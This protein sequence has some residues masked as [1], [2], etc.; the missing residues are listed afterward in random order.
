MVR[1]EKVKLFR[2]LKPFPL[3]SL[4]NNLVLGQYRAGK[5]DGEAVPGYRDEPEVD[6]SSVTPTFAAMRL[7]VDNWRWQG[8]CPFTSPAE[9]A[10]PG[11]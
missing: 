1:D 7:F 10:W 11:K 8:V 9:S 4:N 3:E 2:A 5:V 6:G